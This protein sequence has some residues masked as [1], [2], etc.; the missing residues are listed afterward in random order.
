M[1]R[2]STHRLKDRLHVEELFLWQTVSKRTVPVAYP[3]H[4]VP[5]NYDEKKLE[6]ALEQKITRFLLELGTG[7]AFIGRQVLGSTKDIRRNP[8]R[9]IRIRPLRSLILTGRS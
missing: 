6:D 4:T 5:A 2:Y 9:A 3:W 7:F 8:G 1:L